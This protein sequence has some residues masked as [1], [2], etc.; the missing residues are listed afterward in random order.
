MILQHTDTT[1]PGSVPDLLARAGVS[2]RVGQLHR[3]FELPAPDA[4]DLVVVCG[5]GVHIDQED[6]FTFLRAEKEFLRRAIE[7][8]TRLIG[9]C[10][11]AQLI[12]TVLGARCAPHPGGWEVGW[13]EV[14]CLEIPGLAGF[15]RA[16]TR[17]VSQYHRYVF[18][19]PPGAQTLARNAWCDPQAFRYRDHVLAFGFHPERT[20]QSNAEIA[21]E[22]DLPTT[23][24][25]QMSSEMTRLGRESEPLVTP[26]FER[27]LLG[28]LPT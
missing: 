18:D 25:C 11:G 24:R 8:G 1:T 19:L 7:D 17:R 10:L 13:H 12:A 9:L 22:L 3:G 16:T 2:Y 5:G 21:R 6:K 28:H 15:E 4:H 23:G 14:D 27:I 20:P 26:W